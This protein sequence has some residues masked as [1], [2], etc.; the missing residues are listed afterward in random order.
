[1]TDEVRAAIAKIESAANQKA[2]SL[3]ISVSSYTQSYQELLILF[4][5]GIL[6][7]ETIDAVAK[8]AIATKEQD[9]INAFPVPNIELDKLKTN[10]ILS[11]DFGAVGLNTTSTA[12]AA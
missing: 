8:Q 7:N 5:A 6:T 11:P 3:D 1:M 4:N 2:K 12:A 10:K 9:I